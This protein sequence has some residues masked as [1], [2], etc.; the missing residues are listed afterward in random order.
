MMLAP[1]FDGPCI[2]AFYV[3]RVNNRQA[4]YELGMQC[5]LTHIQLYLGLV[6]SPMTLKSTGQQ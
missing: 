4:Q 1:Q 3:V 6:Y 5:A 2:V